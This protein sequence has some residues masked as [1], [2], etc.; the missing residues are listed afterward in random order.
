[1]EYSLIWL[2]C[3]PPHAGGAENNQIEHMQM[4][5]EVDTVLSSREFTDMIEMMGIGRITMRPSFYDGMLSDSTGVG[6][7]FEMTDGVT[8]AAVRHADPGSSPSSGF[9]IL[10]SSNGMAIIA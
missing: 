4:R 1:M 10:S 2:V 6:V 9:I 8:S 3:R 5:G 7:I